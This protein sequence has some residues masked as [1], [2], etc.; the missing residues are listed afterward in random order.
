MIQH[1]IIVRNDIDE[2]R[3]EI[4]AK[5]TLE[6]MRIECPVTVIIVGPTKTHSIVVE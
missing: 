2:D 5:S 4:I 6:V 3:L 1:E